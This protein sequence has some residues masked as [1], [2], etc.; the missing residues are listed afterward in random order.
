MDETTPFEELLNEYQIAAAEW[1][2]A[3]VTGKERSVARTLRARQSLIDAYKKL[4]RER[5][6]ERHNERVRRIMREEGISRAEAED[7]ALFDEGV[8]RVRAAKR[9][10]P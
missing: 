1:A 5:A 7:K 3:G 2:V 9:L 10:V 8:E 6:E 4:E